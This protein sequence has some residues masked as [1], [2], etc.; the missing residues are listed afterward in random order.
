MGTMTEIVL[1]MID[2]M[3]YE[4]KVVEIWRLPSYCFACP[5][6]NGNSPSSSHSAERTPITQN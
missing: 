3:E 5:N 4:N 1:P 6:L 2:K